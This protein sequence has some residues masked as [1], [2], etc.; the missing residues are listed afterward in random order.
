MK[1]QLTKFAAVTALASAMM[2]AQAPS[3]S[4]NPQAR[5]HNF[6]RQHMA[7]IAQQL[8]LTDAQKQHAKTIF[9]QARQ[10][11]QPV[12]EQLKQN[13]Q[14]LAEAAKAGNSDPTIQQLA[15]TQGNLLGQMV[16]VRTE[17]FAKF[18]ATLTPEQRTKA[19]QLQQQ[20]QQRRLSGQHSNG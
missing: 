3:P 17:A 10:T 16:A 9:Q 11:A 5:P 14:A 4:P 2:F 1:R 19:D 20:F 18:Y 7:R 13:R 15:V 8:N 6:I 12:R